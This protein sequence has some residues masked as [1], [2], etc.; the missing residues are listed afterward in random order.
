MIPD[1]STDRNTDRK[2]REAAALR[3]NLLRRK[4]RGPVREAPPKTPADPRKE[5]P[6]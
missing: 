6:A 1:G 4:A 5:D 2:A 3:E